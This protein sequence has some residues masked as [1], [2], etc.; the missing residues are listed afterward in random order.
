MLFFGQI[1]KIKQKILI[2]LNAFKNL[3]LGKMIFV[4]I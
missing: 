3:L 1:F 2:Q 4:I